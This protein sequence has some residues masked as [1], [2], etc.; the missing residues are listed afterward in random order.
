MKTLVVSLLALASISFT[1]P[2]HAHK[3]LTFQG[4]LKDANGQLVTATGVT[5]TSRLV[6][7][8][9]CV[10]ME[11]THSNVSI[12]SGFFTVV[13]GAGTRTGADKTLA[14]KDVFS[15]S[16]ARTAFDT[17]GGAAGSCNYTP[18]SNDARKV[19]LSFTLGSD[20]I[21][22][23]FNIRANA[24]AV[25]SEAAEDASKLGGK[26]ASDFVQTSTNVT[27]AGL[28]SLMTNIAGGGIPGTSIASVP[29]SKLT[30]IP[31][32]LATIGG[33]T[34]ANGQILKVSGGN[35]ACAAAVGGGTVTDVTSANSYITIATSTSTPALTLH[36]GTTANTVAAGDDSRFGDATKIQGADID[37]TGLGSGKVL[38]YDGTK[39]APAVMSSV[40]TDIASL[41]TTGIVQRNGSASYST[42]S[43]VAPLSYA[44]GN[45]GVTVGT[46]SGTVAAGD[47]ARIGDATKISGV[48]IDT[49]GL[50]TGHVLKYDGTKWA[51]TAGVTPAGTTG[52]VQFNNGGVLG[53]GGN[54]YTD[55][56]YLSIGGSNSSGARLSS[57][58]DGDPTNIKTALGVATGLQLRT[59]RSLPT[60]LPPLMW[61]NS[62]NPTKPKAGIWTDAGASSS[63]LVF[64]TSNNY[65]TGITNSAVTID[66]SGSVG[67]GSDSPRASL[68]V[69]GTILGKPGVSNGTST[70]DFSTGNLQYTTSDCGA[71]N[72]NN[73]KDGGSYM[74]AV[75]GT[76][77]ATCS[78]NAYSDAGTTALT[79][80]M[81][82]DH[83]ATTAGKHTIY[84]LAVM[85]THVYVAWTP[86]Y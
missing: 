70:V 44:A 59:G 53:G 57:Y 52:S 67:I 38:Q 17:L 56:N 76:T 79:V 63:K 32:P 5:I 27:Q 77:S 10:L 37:T 45:L 39:W 55:G 72:L 75:Q 9:N 6:S 3:G 69:N 66:G 18:T 49:T 73:L 23:S 31:A 81:P 65:A 34:C 1:L 16:T 64:G 29:W 40:A 85:G 4:Y 58:T 54:V 25:W 71:F 78:F 11:E 12:T 83:A 62:D 80:H 33:L 13:L 48:S 74:F 2:A 61:S 46:T 19:A 26:T 51:A 86:G 43:V 41:A 50:A 8:N 14:L 24:Y 47:D 35:W 20:S 28:E 22:A 68:D 21:D 60:T 36:V 84:N 15:N 7:P 30:S 82:P 42:V